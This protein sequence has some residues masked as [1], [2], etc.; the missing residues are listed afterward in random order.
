MLIMLIHPFIQTPP[1]RPP[2]PIPCLKAFFHS[3]PKQTCHHLIKL[4]LDDVIGMQNVK[5][6]SLGSQVKTP[7]EI[8]K[9]PEIR[10]VFDKFTSQTSERTDH[11]LGFI[12]RSII[13]HNHPVR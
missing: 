11:L 8:L 7:V 13:Q 9:K 10:W 2:C 6:F 3:F 1:N 5:E 12:T 4:R